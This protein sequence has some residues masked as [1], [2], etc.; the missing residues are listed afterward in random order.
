MQVAASRYW[1]NYRHLSNVLVV[2]QL[3]KQY[4]V[5]EDKIILMNGF[6]D[7]CGIRNPFPGQIYGDTKMK[8]NICEDVVSDYHGADVTV[9]AFLRLLTGRHHRGTP[10][11]KRLSSNNQSSV[12]IFLSGHGGDGFFKFRDFEE[13]SSEEIGLAI[14]EMELKNRY[15]QLLIISD[16]CQAASLTTHVSSR[17]VVSVASSR[18]GENSYAYSPSPKLGVSLID[19]F[20][21]SLSEFFRV[22]IKSQSDLKKFK[23]VD[24]INFMDPKFL[25]SNPVISYTNSSRNLKN[26][27]ISSFF[28]FNGGGTQPKLL[29]NDLIEA[30]VPAFTGDAN[31]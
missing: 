5:P 17:D 18:V 14:S 13:V 19:R 8:L 31:L 28:S 12:L 7:V 3:A 30:G 9:D 1:F 22:S 10:L 25:Q 11:S 24:I 2:Y 4:G 15:K 26:I 29:I 23:I 20:S 16:T 21:Y 6:D 27:R